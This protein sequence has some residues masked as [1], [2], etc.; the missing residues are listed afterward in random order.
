M[1]HSSR[2]ICVPVEKHRRPPPSAAETPVV[3]KRPRRLQELRSA[4]FFHTLCDVLNGKFQSSFGLGHYLNARSFDWLIDWSYDRMM[5]WLIDWLIVWSYDGLIDWLIEVIDIRIFV[6][7][8]GV[9]LVF[10]AVVNSRGH[11][12]GNYYAATGLV[13]IMFSGMSVRLQH[14]QQVK[15]F[16]QNF[17]QILS[18]KSPTVHILLPLFLA[19]SGWVISLRNELVD[20]GDSWTVLFLSTRKPWRS[21]GHFRRW[22]S[23]WTNT[24]SHEG[25]ATAFH[26]VSWFTS[27]R[28]LLCDLQK[29]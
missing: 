4:T 5:D 18:R 17:L 3:F 21:R 27:S 29:K 15:L 13:R 19:G 11:S 8:Y 6:I 16:P 1:E 24:A 14:C 9:S 23:P 2:L 10:F 12:D 26:A 20:H 25:N 7:F 28:P 22:S